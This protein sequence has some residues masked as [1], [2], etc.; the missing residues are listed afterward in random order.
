MASFDHDRVYQLYL[1]FLETAESKR[2]WSIFKDIPWNELDVSKATEVNARR[3]ELFCSEELYLPDYTANALRLLRSMFGMAW[4][5]TCWAYEE[6]RHGLV[7]REYLIRSGLRS[8]AEVTQLEEI[9][10][11]NVWSLPF[12]T[13]RQMACYGA[14]QEGAT[15]TAY[16]IQRDLARSADDKLL[17]TI[18]FLV[19]RDEAAHGGFYRALV[20]M[21][22]AEDR[23]GTI[24]D[25]A[26]VFSK[27]KMPGDGLI[28]DYRQRLKAT[29]AGISPR[30]FLEHVALPLLTTLE[31]PRVE[32]KGACKN[33][34]TDA[35]V[36]SVFDASFR[37]PAH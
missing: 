26:F 35:E 12:E 27:F 11:A 31:I 33:A 37:P 1:N 21:E 25:L 14:L 34:A 30:M 18:F 5:Q 4:F 29:G 2:R 17:E 16:K 13:P 36:D 24:A 28:P 8:E 20:G 15:Y 23:E 10:F 6:S 7:F 9:V 22:L 3:I 32:L 19:G